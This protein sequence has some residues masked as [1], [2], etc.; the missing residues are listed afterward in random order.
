[1]KSLL[2]GDR[3]DFYTD[4]ALY[5]AMSRAGIMHVI[6]VS[7]MHIAFLVGFIQLIFGKTKKSSIICIALIWAF[8]L[9]AG[10]PFSAVR[11]AIMQTVFLLAP[12]FKRETDSFR[13][14]LIAFVLIE[15]IS[16]KAIMDTGFELSFA[17]M[18]GMSLFSGKIY[19][20][21][22]SER[23]ILQ[24]FAG[25][26]SSSLACMIFTVPLTAF[27]FGSIQIL[28]PLTNILVLFAVTL[29]FCLGYI[30]VFSYLIFHPLGKLI[31][32]PVRYLASYVIKAA[33]LI[34]AIPFSC[35]YTKNTAAVIW[36]LFVYAL[37]II[38]L[39]KKWKWYYPAAAC[40][41][42]LSLVLIGTKIFY[43]KVPGVFT[44]VNVGQGQCLVVMGGNKT[45]VIDCGGEWDSGIE[46]GKYLKSCGRNTVDLLLLTH[47]HSDHMNGVETLLQFVDV[48][49]I[50]IPRFGD[51]NEN[52]IKKIYSLCEDNTILLSQI[53][54]DSYADVGRIH[55][56]LFA[57]CEGND[58]NEACI[59]NIATIGD[60]DML[61]TGDSGI[62][63]ENEFINN[64]DIKDIDLLIVGHHGSKNSSGNEFLKSIGANKAIISVGKNEY[65]HPTV[66]ALNRLKSAGYEIE[67]T[68]ELGT[69]ELILR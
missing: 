38:A 2:L 41:V 66:D 68:D 53:Q 37:V 49:E 12:V 16:P 17:A 61:V 48:K 59:I 36:V 9:L 15:L 65:G 63:Q 20:A 4:K 46:A 13:S 56:M 27:R 26:I 10:C 14:L 51:N 39:W 25:I 40:I 67:R 22:Y 44:A 50:V 58:A 21:I 3:T 30:S 54:N 60:Y 62:N 42:S 43:E 29:S 33:K 69:I 19:K 7:G 6:A 64:H 1:M 52:Y 47:L 34:S 18:A 5:I 11:A 55:L 28:S 24:Y 35:V 32:V 45:V 23:R 31:A 8:V 57:P